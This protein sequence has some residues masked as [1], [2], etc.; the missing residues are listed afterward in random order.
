MEAGSGRNLG[1]QV[2]RRK[3]RFMLLFWTLAAVVCAVVVIAL[4]FPPTMPPPEFRPAASPATVPPYDKINYDSLA[5]RPFESGKMWVM[6]LARAGDYHCYVLE[7]NSRPALGELIGSAN[8]IFFSRDGQRLLCM[9]RE[10]GEHPLRKRLT[11]W[12][13]SMTG[14]RLTFSH[15]FDDVES[16]WL[17]DMGGGPGRKIGKVLQ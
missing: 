14:G 3:R 15:D 17:V 16:F 5:D 7:I 8:P 10:D 4:L 12:V 6:V 13:E 1:G 2:E 11:G 9:R